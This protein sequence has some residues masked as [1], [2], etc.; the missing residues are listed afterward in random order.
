MF[1]LLFLKSPGIR[2]IVSKREHVKFLIARNMNKSL[3]DDK[4]CELI[5][6]SN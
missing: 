5:I 4:I 1:H 2:K 6:E 3:F